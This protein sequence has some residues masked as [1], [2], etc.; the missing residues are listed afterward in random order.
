[1]NKIYSSYINYK[2]LDNTPTLYIN[3]I[4]KIVHRTLL[5]D[6][7]FPIE[8][9]YLF[10]LFNYNSTGY[11]TVL[12]RE[13]DLLEI[14]N[15][16][17]KIIYLSYKHRIQKTD[18]ARYMILKKYGGIYAD[19]DI[20]LK[21]HLDKILLSSNKGFICIEEK[22]LTDKKYNESKT[23]K[24]RQTLPL[25]ERGEHKLRIANYFFAC[26]K[27]N[28][29]WNNIIVLCVKRAKYKIYE[30]YDVL[31]TTGPDVITTCIHNILDSNYMNIEI[32]RKKIIDNMIT[33]VQHNKYHKTNNYWKKLL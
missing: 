17:E 21:V 6:Y 8:L 5:F 32:I 24:I 19:F 4:P 13:K 16:T 14:L 23:Y 9:Q 31:F 33:H 25:I 29:I 26:S 18:F 11:K 20:E 28:I 15:S 30:S 7:N 2:E 22:M 10:I 1:M 3:N 12:W 27:N